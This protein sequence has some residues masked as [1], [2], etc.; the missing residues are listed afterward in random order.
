ME[1]KGLKGKETGNENA[2]HFPPF[3][4]VCPQMCWYLSETVTETKALCLTEERDITLFVIIKLLDSVPEEI[5]PIKLALLAEL[6][7]LGFVY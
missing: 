4:E 1:G 7:Y 5:L 6:S 2:A 3:K